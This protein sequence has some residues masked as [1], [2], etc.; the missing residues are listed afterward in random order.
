MKLSFNEKLKPTDSVCLILFT[1]AGAL[2]LFSFSYAKFDY[3]TTQTLEY[4]GLI[5][6]PLFVLQIL[7]TIQIAKNNEKYK[8]KLAVFYTLLLAI[9]IVTAVFANFESADYSYYLK[10]WFNTYHEMS[11]KDA[12]YHITDVSN[13]TQ[14][15][16]YLL[17][18][19]A[20]L[21]FNPL[22]SIKYFS[23]LF[24]IVLA[25]SMEL[26]LTKLN[27]KK[28]NLFHLPI[29][30]LIPS[31]CS[32]FAWWGQ[33]DAIYTSFCLFAFYFAL[34]K[35]SKLSFMFIGLAFASKL[36]FLFIVPILFVM[37]II[38]DDSGNRYLKW[39][40]IW[41]AP[42]M[43]L[44]NIFPVFVGR[45]LSDTLL[46][47]I[48]QTG[49]YQ[50]LSLG[51]ANVCE[52]FAY[53]N[54]TPGT[55]YTILFV[56]QITLSITLVLISV[57]FILKYSKSHTLSAYDLT[58]FATLISFMMVFFM[59]KMLNRFYYITVS[60]AVVMLFEKPTK[61]NFKIALTFE[62]SLYCMMF[63][64]F[65][66]ADIRVITISLI[67][68]PLAIILNIIGFVL[69]LQIFK[70]DYYFNL[71]NQPPQATA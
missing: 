48:N 37:L 12:L 38:K 31:I 54:I 25:V 23:F 8:L 56:F 70:K 35:K 6:I 15:Y 3:L 50:F 18:I 24:S 63:Y 29:F 53:F 26:L 9:F 16:N 10:N 28:F 61:Q 66:F 22:Y 39:K 11:F 57:I 33:C 1:F 17:I 40:D 34:S 60:L 55:L 44:I 45:S 51:C 46:V 71:K 36:Q 49:Y 67:S 2:I 27:N 42:A 64:A 7:G 4:F 59:P 19:F 52:I 30:I 69:M 47:Y 20:K 21:N 65:K 43:Y 32:E 62:L 58:F 41:I 68:T 14:A 5:A 13:Y